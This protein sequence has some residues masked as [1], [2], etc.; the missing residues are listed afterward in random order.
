MADKLFSVERA[1]REIGRVVKLQVQTGPLKQGPKREQY[2]PVNLLEVPV[3][4]ITERG[5]VGWQGETAIMDVHHRDHPRTTGN[6]SHTLSFNFTSHYEVIRGRYGDHIFTGCGGDNLVFAA[7]DA[8]T[9][10]DFQGELVLETQDGRRG[11]V[12][13][14]TIAT[15][16]LSYGR[17]ILNHP[18]PTPAQLKE[19]LQFLQD[20]QRGFYADWQGPPVRIRPGDRLLRLI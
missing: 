12:L 1:M 17:Y 18:A 14:P 7:A 13:P 19:T 8:I 9:L 16:C 4:E 6:K 2:L 11:R 20:G 10:A 3:L 5:V 15:P